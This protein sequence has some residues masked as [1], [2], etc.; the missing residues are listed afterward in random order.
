MNGSRKN[1]KHDR[2]VK[3]DLPANCL[4]KIALGFNSSS[5]QIMGGS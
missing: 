1:C 3:V 2:F 4:Y 5:I